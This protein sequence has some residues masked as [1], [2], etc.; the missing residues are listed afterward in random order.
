MKLISLL[1]VCIL[2]VFGI[3]T[4]AQNHNDALI[5]KTKTIQPLDHFKEK[6]DALKRYAIENGFS[7]KYAVFVDL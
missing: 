6:E 5:G 1:S 2:I 4:I 7:N 3:Q